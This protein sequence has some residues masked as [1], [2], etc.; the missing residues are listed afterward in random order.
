MS[1][2]EEQGDFFLYTIGAVAAKL[3]EGMKFGNER[4]C[5][6]VHFDR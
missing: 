2:W 4:S 5:G 6:T 1:Q 3:E